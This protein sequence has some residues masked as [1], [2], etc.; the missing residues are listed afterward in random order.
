[1]YFVYIDYDK[2]DECLNLETPICEKEWPGFKWLN[3]GRDFVTKLNA[4]DEK[5]RE[6]SEQV[7]LSCPCNA[8]IFTDAV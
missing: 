5:K 3:G 1:M 6:K 2:C 8:V 4:S 7:K